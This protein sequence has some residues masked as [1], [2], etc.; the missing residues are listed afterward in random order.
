[1]CVLKKVLFL[2]FS[3]S[4]LFL[5]PGALYKST[6]LMKCF[7]LENKHIRRS[8]IKQPLTL[9][10]CA[11]KSLGATIRDVRIYE[12][13]YKIDDQIL[14]LRILLKKIQLYKSILNVFK[15]KKS[16]KIYTMLDTWGK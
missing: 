9:L 14:S 13:I 16:T 11:C 4:L 6:E 5:S 3:F 2:S 8:N 1:M 7:L 12:F 10:E 15:L